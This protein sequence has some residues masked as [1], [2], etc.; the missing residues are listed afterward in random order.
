MI[1]TDLHHE[2]RGAGPAV[3]FIPG[4]S[5]D[6]GH[7]AGVAER[8]VDEFT[9]VSYDRRGSSRSPRLPAGEP[10][11]V[12]A[13]ADDAATLIEALAIAPAMVFGTSGGG[14]ILLELIARRPD[15]VRAALVHEPALIAILPESDGGAISRSA[16]TGPISSTGR[17]RSIR[18][19]ASERG[20]AGKAAVSGSWM[21]TVLPASLT[22][23]APSAPSD[24]EPVR[25]TA[26]SRSPKIEAA[27]A[28]SKST[29]GVGRRVASR[30]TSTWWSVMTT[31]RL[32][33]TT[34]IVP[35][36]SASS[37]STLRLGMDVWRERISAR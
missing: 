24:P 6:A 36:V 2:V 37:T 28:S 25:M 19:G 3:L 7:F 17:L 20:M 22:A 35:G 18:D 26:I 8:L 16:R 33:G 12:A 29:E 1:A 14:T 21:I 10:M 30:W 27:L 5:G 11:S 4:A 13:Q 15:V 9:V 32:A 34:K 31:W 23:W